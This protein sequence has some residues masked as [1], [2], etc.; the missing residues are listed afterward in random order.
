MILAIDTSTATVSVALY[1]GTE[2]LGEST[3]KSLNRHT[4]LLAPTVESLMKQTGTTF[5]KV[6]ALAVA[7]GP[8]SFTSLRVGLS[9]VKG[10]HAALQL[11]VIGIPTLSYFAAAQPASRAT[12]CTLLTAGRGKFAT[13]FFE[14][15]TNSV[16]AIS[17]IDVHTIETLAATIVAPT[18]V[19]GEITAETKIELKRSH[20]P[21][22][23]FSTN[24]FGL[25]RAGF[26]AV[27]AWKRFRKGTFDDADTL[28]PIYL[29]T[30]DSILNTRA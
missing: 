3:Y 13:Q 28:T 23:R 27:Q 15:K 14:V 8:G 19:T 30:N 21:N 11:P 22:I 4:V 10:I 12:V 25:R 29:H 2:I 18:V 20:N 5:D 7:L 1:D 9:F 17:E 26:L 24:G 16:T 6:T